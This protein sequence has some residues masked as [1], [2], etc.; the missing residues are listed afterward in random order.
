MEKQIIKFGDIELK[1]QKF[2]KPLYNEI[3]L[4]AKIK[5][6]NRKINTNFYNSKIP[7]EG[8]Q[9]TCLSVIFI[10]SGFRASNNYYP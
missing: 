4:K 8:F 3:Y 9:C 6:Y 10:D 7:E 2:S 5:S 1:K